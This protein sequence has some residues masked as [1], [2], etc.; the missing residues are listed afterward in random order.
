MIASMYSTYASIQVSRTACIFRQI[1]CVIF[2][3]YCGFFSLLL[4]VKLGDVLFLNNLQNLL[5]VII[6]Q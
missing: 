6:G 3:N 1:V 4:F 5:S 2:K